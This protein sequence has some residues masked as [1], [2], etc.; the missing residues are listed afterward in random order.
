[1]NP[2]IESYNVPAHTTLP[3]RLCLTP[4]SSWLDLAPAK[5]SQHSP[6][7]LMGCLELY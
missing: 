5:G 2:C 6:P 1:M 4:T 7:A 3:E